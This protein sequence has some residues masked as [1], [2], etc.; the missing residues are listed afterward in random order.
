MTVLLSEV[1]RPGPQFARSV[2]IE[3]DLHANDVGGY[4]P[5]GR[6]LDVL[7]RFTAALNDPALTRA[8]SITGPYGSGKS[9]LALLLNCLAGPVDERAR[10]DALALVSSVDKA[11][12]SELGTALGA[13]T[14]GGGF[15]RA[16][17]TA[18]REPTERTIVRAVAAGLDR[19][20][21]APR[22]RAALA[23]EAE[24]LLA[25]P[26]LSA[27]PVADLVEAAAGLAPVLLVIDEFGKNLEFFADRPA[28]ADLFVLQE[29]V[30]RS[31]GSSG[32]PVFV[33]T[34]QHLAFE[35]YAA[36]ATL[37]QRREWAKV[38]G[39]FEDVP[40]ADSP[41]EVLQLV[42][43]VFRRVDG[44]DPAVLAAIDQ[45]A[46][47]QYKVVEQLGL[48]DRLPGPD[49]LSA[50][51]P[52][53]PLALAVLPE[54]CSRYGQRERTLF[55]FLARPEPHA[56]AS[57][58]EEQTASLSHLPVVGVEQVFD[59]FTAMSGTIVATADGASRWVEIDSRIKET[60]G[61]S[62]DETRVM[63]IAGVLNLVSRGGTIRASREALTYAAADLDVD[64]ILKALQDR[65][66]LVHRGFADEFR[67]WQGTDFDLH[68]AVDDARRRVASESLARVCERALPLSPVVAARH[69]QDKGIL[70]FFDRTYADASGLGRAPS[71]EAD[72][73]LLYVLDATPPAQVSDRVNDPRPTIL[74]YPSE[75]EL[76]AAT[77]A[78]R[79]AAA[80]A[81]VL[82][83]NDSLAEDWVARRELH[84]RAALAADRFRGAFNAAFALDADG[85][86]V[87]LADGSAIDR[88]GRRTWSALLS[89]VCDEVYRS[90]PTV[91]N[92]VIARR[93][94]S[95]QGARARR[96]LL[97]AMIERPGL[98][99]L[100]IEGYGP[101]RAILDSVLVHSGMY[102]RAGDVWEF[103]PPAA[104]SDYVPAW[105]AIEALLAA[106]DSRPVALNDLWQVL[107]SPP[108]GLPEGPIPVLVTAALLV[109]ADDVAV[110]QDGTFQPVFGAELI[111]RMIKAPERFAVKQFATRG[112]RAR[113]LGAL[114]YRLPA[115]APGER[116]NAALVRVLA[117]LVRSALS[118]PEYTRRTSALDD[119][120][121]SVRDALTR[122]T[123]PDVLLFSTLPQALGMRAFTPTGRVM[124]EQASEYAGRVMGSLARL[125]NVYPALID[126]I[127]D[128]LATG[129][130][131]PTPARL[132]EVRAE[133]TVRCGGLVDKV[134][135]PRLRSFLM[136]AADTHL[137]DHD[138][139]E[140]LAMNVAERPP[141]A[142][143][144]DDRRRFETGLDELLRAYRRVEIL[145][146]EH[147]DS[148]PGGAR[149][150]QVVVTTPEGDVTESVV[151]L[152]DTTAEAVEEIVANALKDASTLVGGRA[153]ETLLAVLAER[154]MDA[155][156]LRLTDRRDPTLKEARRLHA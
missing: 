57:F 132:L 116:R 139:V 99:H 147:L 137:E 120:A 131:R 136:A 58:L 81:D 135:E 121:R 85:V 65:G 83:T 73:V 39:R 134:I 118:L 94:L 72:G 43:R 82:A 63:K 46:E 141:R 14:D 144:D 11:L 21:G 125:E 102:R 154:L 129:F 22:R 18:Q 130:G 79:D 87:V 101:E 64:A 80:V 106:A 34:L 61:L 69:S 13:A 45:W 151:W 140:N 149:A 1:L 5:T 56:V 54:L 109:H 128:A 4:L 55:S 91:R 124:Y 117:P 7:R 31:S 6:A 60:Q 74:I 19:F 113:V 148:H 123:E 152:D 122:A 42:A 10:D 68:G 24:R 114:A 89:D 96:D 75:S 95:S 88:R 126:S 40:F 29:I 37:S 119:E 145:H 110:Y 90:A 26:L 76:R 77:G 23:S 100:G 107:Q 146:L 115:T 92:E 143:R 103:A 66:L 108:I 71:A 12:A 70:R 35:D 20:Q 41:A 86:E 30:E 52:L 16:A 48:G 17:V 36:S 38:Q 62:D 155:G 111:E 104:D 150:R 133:V 59:Y 142:W 98:E 67:I 78:A 44:A 138:W 153:P 8:W 127:V 156:A 93:E 112:P 2:N 28:E 84:E 25:A 47:T 105:H 49:V 97:M 53:H 51:Y 9:A 15:L 27:R 32:P 3:R 33:V 50:C